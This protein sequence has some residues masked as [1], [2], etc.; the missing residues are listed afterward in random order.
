M[1]YVYVLAENGSWDYELTG[2]VDVYSTFEKALKEFRC[3]V[4]QAKQ[5]MKE[6]TDNSV[7]EQNIHEKSED[8]TFEIYE[9]G[10]YTRLHDTITIEKKCIK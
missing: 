10:E 8:A 4:E 5:D 3:K 6:W 2:S 1:E 7:C 9:I